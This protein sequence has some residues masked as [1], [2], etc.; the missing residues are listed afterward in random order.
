MHFGIKPSTEIMPC[1][2]KKFGVMSHIMDKLR[3]FITQNG[4][5]EASFAALIGANQSTIN[6]LLSG[7]RKPSL[8]TALSIE[9]ATKGKVKAQDWTGK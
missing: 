6:R 1:R 8:K 7:D 5:T 4:H 3:N 2:M 9:K